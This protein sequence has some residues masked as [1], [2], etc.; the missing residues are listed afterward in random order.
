MTSYHVSPIDRIWRSSHTGRSRGV[1]LPTGGL[2]K[3]NRVVACA[4]LL[5][6][7]LL[8]GA[9]I[10]HASSM[11]PRGLGSPPDVL[12]IF[13]LVAGLLTASWIGHC[14]HRKTAGRVTDQPAGDDGHND[15]H[16]GNDK[17]VSVNVLSERVFDTMVT[18]ER[19]RADRSGSAFVLMILDAEPGADARDSAEHTLRRAVPAIMSVTRQIDFLGW[20]GHQLGVMFTG[21]TAQ[22][23]NGV[24]EILRA[25]VGAALARSLGVELAGKISISLPE[26]A[27]LFTLPKPAHN[28]APLTGVEPAAAAPGITPATGGAFAYL[29]QTV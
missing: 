19:K 6:G 15:R 23:G 8:P 10:V 20:R 16:V 18:L 11:A 14:Y 24:P 12:H 27:P 1:G 13:L 7:V 3:N 21:I 28:V 22:D 5:W 9:A 26:V 17:S 4:T 25:K 2:I 29:N